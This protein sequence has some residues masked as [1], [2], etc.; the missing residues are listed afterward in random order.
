MISSVGRY[1]WKSRKK[2]YRF[3]ELLYRTQASGS[4]L[5]SVLLSLIEA[6]AFPFCHEIRAN[7]CL[8]MCIESVL[9]A[10]MHWH[11]VKRPS[12]FSIVYATVK[13]LPFFGVALP[14]ESASFC[15]QLIEMRKTAVTHTNGFPRSL[16]LLIVEWLFWMNAL[17]NCL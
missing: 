3:A 7:F 13:C 8:S 4:E 2:K 14:L 16:E 6:V 1:D 12:V 5:G 17:S 10:L 11:C 15:W 9:A